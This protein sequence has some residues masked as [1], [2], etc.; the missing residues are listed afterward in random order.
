MN[1]KPLTDQIHNLQAAVHQMY[2]D[3]FVPF[4]QKTIID[5][6]LA[7]IGRDYKLLHQ[8]VIRPADRKSYVPFAA[9]AANVL[10]TL[11]T[12][13]PTDGD[14]DILAAENAIAQAAQVI[15]AQLSEIMKLEKA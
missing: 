14:A 10:V 2:K 13:L 9:Q 6:T 7:A 15:A 5:N 11:R 12:A 4:P 1:S 3:G 8:P